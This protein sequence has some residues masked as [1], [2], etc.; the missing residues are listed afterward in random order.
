[1]CKAM[2]RCCTRITFDALR[3]RRDRLEERSDRIQEIIHRMMDHGHFASP[4]YDRL[5]L[6][7]FESWGA[8]RAIDDLLADVIKGVL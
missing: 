5:R 3:E 4:L 2:D 6:R 8:S 7:K 1:M